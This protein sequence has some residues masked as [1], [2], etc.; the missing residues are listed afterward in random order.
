[1]THTANLE[2]CRAAHAYGIGLTGGSDGHI[3]DAMGTAVTVAPADSREG[4]LD[5]IVKNRTMAIGREKD[6][7][8][9]ILTGS[10]SFTK[11]LG[12]APSAAHAQLETASYSTKRALRKVRNQG[13]RRPR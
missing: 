13:P 6:L 4:I 11:F 9:K 3:L 2:A 7:A 1:M 10:A 8:G 5:S 12:H